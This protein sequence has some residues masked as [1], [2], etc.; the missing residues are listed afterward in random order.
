MNLQELKSVFVTN[1]WKSADA[2]YLAM[3][4]LIWTAL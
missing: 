2:A 4:Q 1:S 3:E